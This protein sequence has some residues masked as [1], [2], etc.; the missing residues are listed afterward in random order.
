MLWFRSKRPASPADVSAPA[1]TP[2]RTESDRPARP[3]VPAAR[4]TVPAA[5]RP[6]TPLRIVPLR[7]PGAPE[8][9]APTAANPFPF[10][11]HVAGELRAPAGDV[12][13]AIRMLE[14]TGLTDEQ[15][16]LV[17]TVRAR[18]ELLSALL[19]HLQEFARVEAGSNGAEAAPFDPLVLVED[20]FDAVAAAAT[21]RSVALA[22]VPAADLPERFVGDP[23]RLGAVLR[24]VLG[25]T[26]A[27]A[28][29]GE[30]VVRLGAVVPPGASDGAPRAWLRCVVEASGGGGSDARLA[31]L[32]D[33]FAADAAPTPGRLGLELPL[34]RRIAERMGGSLVAEASGAA[35]VRFVFEVGLPVGAP[36][37]AGRQPLIAG[38]RV[39][40][41]CA[42]GALGEMVGAYLTHAGATAEVVS[43]A[44][45]AHEALGAGRFDAAILDAD[46]GAG[47]GARLLHLVRQHPAGAALPCVELHRVG[48]K[49]PAT[50]PHT[51]V[52]PVTRTALYAALSATLRTADPAPTRM[53]DPAPAPAAPSALRILLVEDN[54]VNQRVAIHLLSRLGHTATIAGN[55]WE[56]IE[57][58]SRAPFD[59]VLMDVMMPVMDGFD[60]TRH[61][62]A[63]PTEV[64]PR[65]IAL[66]ANA[67]P[68]DRERCLAAGMDDYLAKP[69]QLA[70]LERVLQTAAAPAPAADGPAAVS[71]VD[72][73]DHVVLRDLRGMLG[74]DDP[75]FLDGLVTEFLTDADRLS[76]QLSVA[77]STADLPTARR[78][79]HTLKS[80]SAMFGAKNLSA[81][82]EAIERLA[83]EDDLDGA[84]QAA[85]GFE[86]EV[87]RVRAAL[88]PLLEGHF[89]AL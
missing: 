20:A 36:H 54:D 78:A 62:R 51:L 1:A 86:L 48:H 79:A 67:M 81:R 65:I 60:A 85:D 75:S 13:S 66:T 23:R 40:V 57:A 27:V 45:G 63:L 88:E 77:L 3:A 22:F 31:A 47:A 9:A 38:R 29:R 28:A 24:H 8:P 56:A 89:E 11:A 37:T 74:E 50:T 16:D 58:F 6:E 61:I 59:L 10:L 68:G 41:A 53:A 30:V 33:P 43:S 25:H 69:I 55:G 7:T 83:A 87:S 73:L 14:G 72:P 15:R 46:L 64:R 44:A 2:A 18:G 12:L 39:L 32:F 76:A 84:R 42:H 52:K 17:E 5:A 34:A 21:E 4:P 82:C 71:D 80:S 19:G 35:G 26:V 70:A 49:P